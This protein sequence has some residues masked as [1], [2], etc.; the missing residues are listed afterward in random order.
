MLA[1]STSGY[2]GD[3]GPA[4]QALLT[5]P[6]GIAYAGDVLYVLDT[7]NSC[8]RKIDAQGIITTVA[9]K[10]R[11]L[12]DDPGPGPYPWDQAPIEYPAAIACGPDGPPTGRT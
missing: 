2:A 5:N 1:G 9:R 8:V 11:K 3:G 6:A 7:G 12:E 10:A 4:T